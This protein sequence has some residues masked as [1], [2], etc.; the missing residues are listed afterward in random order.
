MTLN[1]TASFGADSVG[2][3]PEA[4]GVLQPLLATAQASA[5]AVSGGVD[6]MTLTHVAMAAMPEKPVV[7]HA[8][9][10]A[11]PASATARVRVHAARHGWD[12]RV[13]DAGE[14]RDARYIRN[15]VNR[16]Y[17]C[18]TNLYEFIRREWAGPL[19]SGANLDDLSDYRPGLRAAQEH[20]VRHPFVEAGIDK[21]AVRA[22]ARHLRLE[23]VSELPA[24]PCLA[25]RVE[26]GRPID[27]THMH[28]IDRVETRIRELLGPADVRCRVRLL[29][30]CVEIASD[31]LGEL[32]PSIL[33]EIQGLGEREAADARLPFMGVESYVRGSAF[34]S[35]VDDKS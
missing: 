10:P 13:V 21:A 23:D 12:L 18:K 31:R 11:V 8:V 34:V 28:L 2:A 6:S 9:S 22:I 16:C 26:T 19:F 27:A 14:M 24:Q 1:T 33:R 29:G 4:L 35:R 17:F 3:A 15:P 7:F 25:S 32:D 5:I 30:L 20:G